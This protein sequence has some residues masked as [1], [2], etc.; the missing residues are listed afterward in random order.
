MTEL[1]IDK[2]ANAYVN[3][4]KSKKHSTKNPNWWAVEKFMH[5][6]TEELSAADC[7]SAILNILS[8]NPSDKVIAILAAGPLEDLIHECGE[9][10][11][12][13]IEKLA[14]QNPKFRHLLGGVWES[15]TPEIWS[16]IEACRGEVW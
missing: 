14:R 15:S 6:G 13:D 1:V 8:K 9:Q 10:V 3:Y 7:L 12:D 11:I 4:Y 5:V 2:L 16:R